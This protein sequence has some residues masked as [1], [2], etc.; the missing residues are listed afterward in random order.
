MEND[1]TK[2]V[3]A[4]TL[5]TKLSKAGNEYYVLRVVFSNGY[6]VENFVNQDQLFIIN[7]ILNSVH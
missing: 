2:N 7:S 6:A 1:I 3:K 5:A 4:V